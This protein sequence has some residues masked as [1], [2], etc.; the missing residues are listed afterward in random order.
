M[1]RT[2]WSGSLALAGWIMLG[3]AGAGC[4]SSATPATTA[5]AGTPD[6]SPAGTVATDDDDAVSADLKVHHRNHHH[7][8][9]AMF[10][11]MAA[12]TVGATP[13]QQAAIDKIK[14]DLHAKMGPAHEAEKALLTTLAD[15][16]AAG[17]I[18]MAKVDAAVTGVAA[19][20]GQVHAATADAVNQLHA[21]LRPEQ[22][23]ALVDKVE[24]HWL[25]WKNANADE[26]TA[27]EHEEGGR[28]AHMQK[29][30]G[31]S[32]DQV[33]KIKAGFTAQMSAVSAA[34][35][36]FNAAE[37]DAHMKAFGAAFTADQF[38]S[39]SLTSADG[40]NAHMA[41]WGATRMARFYETVSPTLTPEQRAKLAALIREH[42][43]HQHG[44]EGK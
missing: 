43:T 10:I 32:A 17:N 42:A 37:V 23:A 7:G 29:E 22:R 34:Q 8:G 1:N 11:L 3:V 2:L 14:A 15:G 27:H 40:T 41:T 21:V 25:L 6:V 28:I 13:E 12:D 19:A 30:L 24:A 39:R 9:F 44:H 18:D 35:G 38:D 31:L 5:T 16:V 4:G 33:E 20:A 26:A 36:K